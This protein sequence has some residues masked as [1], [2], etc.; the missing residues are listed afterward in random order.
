MPRGYWLAAHT[1]I[2]LRYRALSAHYHTTAIHSV[3]SIIDKKGI[4]MNIYDEPIGSTEHRLGAT[5][6][7]E[8]RMREDVPFVIICS[9]MKYGRAMLGQLYHADLQTAWA[10][11][12]AMYGLSMSSTEVQK[13]SIDRIITFNNQKHEFG[14]RILGQHPKTFYEDFIRENADRIRTR[15]KAN[16]RFMSYKAD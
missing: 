13:W 1:L 7:Y 5:L 14:R 10:K 4:K 2:L 15:Q 6:S 8:Q 3:I 12:I 11:P 16:K 9:R